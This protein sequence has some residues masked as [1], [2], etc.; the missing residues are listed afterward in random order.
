[1][2]SVSVILLLAAGVALLWLLSRMRLGSMEPE[3]MRE[4]VGEH[5]PSFH[6]VEIRTPDGGCDTVRSLR[7]RRFL[8]AEAPPI[9]LPSCRR[10][11]CACYYV[12][13]EDRRSTQR[14]NLQAQAAY[15][16]NGSV[17]ERRRSVGRRASDHI[18][19]DGGH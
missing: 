3:E 7:G 4:Q 19:F 16:A 2:E 13:H 14:R 15:A 9:P 1:M 18:L 10:D 6:A 8:S 5:R 12:H 17:T 11:T